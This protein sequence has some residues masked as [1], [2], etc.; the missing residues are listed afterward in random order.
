MTNQVIKTGYYLDTIT[1]SLVKALANKDRRSVSGFI[2][3]LV[4]KEAKA[5][6]IT[7]IEIPLPQ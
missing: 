1:V 4:R 6:G 3:E 5:Q 2:R 7:T